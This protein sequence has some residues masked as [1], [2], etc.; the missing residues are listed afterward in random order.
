MASP[1][2]TR[3]VSY[4][5]CDI[6]VVLDSDSVI[7]SDTINGMINVKRVVTKKELRLKLG[8]TM[9]RNNGHNKDDD[10]SRRVCPE[11]VHLRPRVIFTWF[12]LRLRAVV[13]HDKWND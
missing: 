9:G 6:Y 7:L 8:D 11:G 4:L 13:G 5:F 1:V 3:E 10:D 2:R 12:G